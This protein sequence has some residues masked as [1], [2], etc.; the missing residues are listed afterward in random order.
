MRQPLPDGV[1]YGNH[2]LYSLTIMLRVD[3]QWQ[4]DG[5]RLFEPET[6]Q[7]VEDW[8]SDKTARLYRNQST[9]G[10]WDGNWPDLDVD[11]PDPNTDP[12]SRRI[13]ATGHALEWW[14]MAPKKLH[15]PR[16][17]IVR[18]GQWLTQTIS[19]MDERTVQKNYTFLSHAGRALAL[20]RGKFPHEVDLNDSQ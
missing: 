14:A 15:P 11:I 3:S 4:Q 8:L 12:L 10:Y 2:R 18:A 16:E 20:W 19:G 13:L 5:K 1:C 9:A 6:R 7:A 17:T